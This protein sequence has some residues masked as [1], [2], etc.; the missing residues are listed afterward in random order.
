MKAITLFLLIV[1]S[2][3]SVLAQNSFVYTENDS[4]PNSVSAFIVNASTGALTPV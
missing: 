3:M 4:N 1:A 2:G